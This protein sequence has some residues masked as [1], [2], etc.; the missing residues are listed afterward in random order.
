M[1]GAYNV[2]PV[3]KSSHTMRECTVWLQNEFQVHTYSYLLIV[4]IQPEAKDKF[5]T[6][7]TL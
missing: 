3:N 6:A 2:R 7:V 4:T 5:L 1:H